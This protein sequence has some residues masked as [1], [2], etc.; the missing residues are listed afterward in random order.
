MCSWSKW[1]GKENLHTTE[2]PYS[3]HTC[4]HP[5]TDT[6]ESEE[7]GNGGEGH[8]LLGTLAVNIYCYQLY[9]GESN[10]TLKIRLAEHSR[11]VQK[12]DVMGEP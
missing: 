12:S 8:S 11:A 2:H 7:P 9:T 3:L 5:E 10:R 6:Y 1:E 4:M